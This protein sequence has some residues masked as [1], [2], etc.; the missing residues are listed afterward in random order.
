MQ[1]TIF[2]HGHL[3]KAVA[4]NFEKGDNQVNFITHENGAT[5]GE[6]VIFAVPFQAID[7]IINRYKD[8]LDGKVVVD[9]TNPLNF[10]NWDLLVPADSSS[11]AVTAQKLPNSHVLKAFNTVTA[12]A[13][14]AGKLANDHAPQV[15]IAGDDDDAKQKLT[16]ALAA[17]PLETVNIGPL[18]RACDLEALGRIEL[19]M[20]FAKK[21]PM[22]GGFLVVK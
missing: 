6:L 9:A 2:G 15:L 12:G 8:Q 3:A 5:V 4:A 10:Q 22:N 19:S 14:T 11:A 1:I 7:D 20:A 16:S 13:M 21:L 18:A 17:S